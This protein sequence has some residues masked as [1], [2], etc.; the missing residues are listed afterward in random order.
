MEH[1][2]DEVE[3]HIVGLRKLHDLCKGPF[4]NYINVAT[5]GYAYE[6]TCQQR[7]EGVKKLQN[8]V[9]VVYKYQIS[10]SS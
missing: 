3:M 7:R 4:I 6:E 8:P 10:S 5:S 9:N 1:F 2:G